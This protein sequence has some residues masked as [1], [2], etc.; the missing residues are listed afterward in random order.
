MHARPEATALYNFLIP[1]MDTPHAGENNM[2]MAHAFIDI[3]KI[4]EPKEILEIG[5]NRGSSALMWLLLSDANV[6]SIDL[7]CK[8]KSVDTLKLLFEDRFHFEKMHSSDIPERKDWYGKF[9]LIFIDGAHDRC[10]IESDSQ[11]SAKLKPKFIAM[12]DVLHKAH[13][14]DFMEILQN[15]DRLVCLKTWGPL[16]GIALFYLLPE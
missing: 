11:N 10:Y 12:D 7:E 4:C 3:V 5:F 1:K 2:G 16:P 6:T 9:D 13:T 15:F 8:P 14:K